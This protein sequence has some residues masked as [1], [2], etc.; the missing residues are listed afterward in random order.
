MLSRAHH[1]VKYS[2]RSADARLKSMKVLFFKVLNMSTKPDED[3]D[4]KDERGD[5]TERK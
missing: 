4:K 3:M 5:S 2:S 1:N